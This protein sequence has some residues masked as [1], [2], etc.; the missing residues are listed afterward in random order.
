MFTKQNIDAYNSADDNLTGA[1]FEKR[2]FE[3]VIMVLTRIQ[4]GFYDPVTAH[5]KLIEV[6]DGLQWVQENLNEK[7]I[8]Q[9]RTMLKNIYSLSIQIINAAIITGQMG[10]LSIVISSIRTIIEPY[11]QHPKPFP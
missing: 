1:Y 7:L 2:W 6:C 10:Y 8:S 9:H 3:S 11:N 5:K 4:A